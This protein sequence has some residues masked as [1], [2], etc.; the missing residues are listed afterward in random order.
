MKFTGVE[1]TVLGLLLYSS[2][3]SVE[4]PNTLASQLFTSVPQIPEVNNLKEEGFGSQFQ[5]D[6]P[7]VASW[8][9]IVEQ[10]IMVVRTRDRRALASLHD[11]KKREKKEKDWGVGEGK[12]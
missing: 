11:R 2:M 10:N 5:T 1:L 8:S 6:Q 9:H 12:E 7:V 3:T 4:L